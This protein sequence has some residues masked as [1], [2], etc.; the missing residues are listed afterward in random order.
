VPGRSVI[1]TVTD[2]G[3]GMAE[4]VRRRVFEPFFST[5]G[6]K[7]SGLGL[8]MAYSIVRRHGGDIRVDSEP[9]HGTTFTLS[10]PAVTDPGEATTPARVSTSRRQARLLV[11]DDE[12]QVL[13]TLTQLIE[14]AG[15][16][17]TAASSGAAALREYQAGRFDAVL[18]NVGMAG[19]NGWD[20]AERLRAVD[21]AVPIVFIT[22]WGMREE[23]SGRLADL[24]VHRCLFKPVRPDEL[25]AAI[26]DAL[27]SR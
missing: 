4:P 5:K 6:D 24:N 20:F 8:S 10:F 25:D 19:M 9:G 1:I 23:D 2:S 7:G 14:S 13:T 12:P 26:Q 18:S 15:H 11:V 16:T 27:Q 3:V 17:V 22:G 21:G